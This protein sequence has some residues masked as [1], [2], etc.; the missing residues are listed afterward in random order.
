MK[1]KRG[2]S[3]DLW[4]TLRRGGG[5]GHMT[6]TDVAFQCVCCIHITLVYL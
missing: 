4:L 2:C 6:S 5:G 3:I 1:I